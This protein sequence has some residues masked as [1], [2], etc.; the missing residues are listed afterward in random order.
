[1]VQLFSQILADQLTLF[2]TVCGGA[3]YAYHITTRP[4]PWIFRTSYSP[5]M[6]RRQRAVASEGLRGAGKHARSYPQILKK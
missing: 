2:Q 6:Q 3:G 4:P 5:K 1:M